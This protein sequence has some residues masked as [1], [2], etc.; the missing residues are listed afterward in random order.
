M[1][2]GRKIA[3]FL[4]AEFDANRFDISNL[5]L[6][7]ILFFVHG[8][9]LARNSC[10]LIKNHFEAWEHGPV[11]RTVYHEFK[12]FHEQ[13]ITVFAEH[14]NYASGRNE[15]I[16]FEDL[17]TH[18]RTFITKVAGYFMPFSA[19]QLRDMTHESDSPWSRV[20]LS[21]P[22]SRGIRD[23]IPNDLIKQYFSNRYGNNVSN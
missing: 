2:D 19:W 5:K 21:N 11:I 8:I 12:K 14:L 22:D 4:L 1:Y 3:N 23:R 10:P 7:K 17:P 20:F 16:G 18:T 9:F 6:N 15:V 13:P